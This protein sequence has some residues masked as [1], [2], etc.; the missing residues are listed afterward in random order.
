[1]KLFENS[2]YF[3]SDSQSVAQG[4]DDCLD[5]STVVASV[6]FTD[7]VNLSPLE[8]DWIE[9][10]AEQGN[11]LVLESWI[12]KYKYFID[13][14][15]SEVQEEGIKHC[16]NSTLE[17]ESS[18]SANHHHW[19]Q[20][21]E[22]HQIQQYQYYQNWFSQWWTEKELVNKDSAVVDEQS[23]S[24][25]DEESLAE[26]ISIAAIDFE[27]LTLQTNPEKKMDSLLSDATDANHSE[28]G[29]LEKTQDFLVGLRLVSNIN[30][31]GS[32]IS[33]CK[34]LTMKKKKKKKKGKN[35]KVFMFLLL[36]FILNC[37]L[38]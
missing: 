35:K 6:D 18:E 13:T 29:I 1:M 12:E 30:T 25:V 38:S 28:K 21:W 24:E 32:N 26:D 9:Y 3:F 8:S 15:R 37:T 10:W 36:H 16:S 5:S 7:K 27:N 19:T 20:L 17:T 4:L 33:S 2:V 31:T 11:K 34:V 22:E 23:N 14:Q